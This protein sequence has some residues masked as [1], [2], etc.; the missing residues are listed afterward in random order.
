MPQTQTANGTANR[1][2]SEVFNCLKSSGG[3]IAPSTSVPCKIEELPD[4][5]ALARLKS[6]HTPDC[7]ADPS[8][9]RTHSLLPDDAGFPR[10]QSLSARLPRSRKTPF[11]SP[12]TLRGSIGPHAREIGSRFYPVFSNVSSHIPVGPSFT[13][14]WLG[15][16]TRRSASLPNAETYGRAK[17]HLGHAARFWLRLRRVRIKFRPCPRQVPGC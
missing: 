5:F 3:A 2:V 13:L 12:I 11:R 4:R 9:R 8:G 17:F 7:E 14:A 10:A 6:D 16:R 1:R 15:A